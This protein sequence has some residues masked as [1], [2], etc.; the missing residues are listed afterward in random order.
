MVYRTILNE[1]VSERVFVASV[2]Q[3]SQAGTLS[4]GERCCITVAA[5]RGLQNK[6]VQISLAIECFGDATEPGRHTGTFKG[7]RDVASPWP[8]EQKG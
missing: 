6:W 8:V 5:W 3:Q 1:W 4:R 7:G 2:M